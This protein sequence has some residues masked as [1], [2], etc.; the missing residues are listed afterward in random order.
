MLQLN[1][2]YTTANIMIDD[3]EPECMSQITRM[4]NHPVFSKQVVIMP[5]T[6][7]G[8]GSV[9]GFTMP[10]TDL[11]I[12]N[13]IGVDI[14][15]GM[16]SAKL[17]PDLPEKLEKLDRKIQ[18]SI[19]MSTSIHPHSQAETLDFESANKTAQT[20]ILNYNQQFGTNYEMPEYNKDWL[21]KKLLQIGIDPKRFYHSI[22]TLGGGNHFIEIGISDGNYY[23]TVHSGSRHFGAR[24]AEYWQHKAKSKQEPANEQMAD[25]IARLQKKGI[26]GKQLNKKIREINRKNP[27]IKDKDLAPLDG[28]DMMAYLSDMVF[29][30]QYASLNRHSMLRIILENIKVAFSGEIIESVHN[31]IDFE[32]LVIR[33]GAIRSYKTEKMI[34]PFNMRDGILICEGKSNE[35][36]NFSAPHG[37]GRIM[38]RSKA[39]K[40]VDIEDYKKSMQGI[41]STCINKNT[42]DESPMVY[43]NA[44]LI[45]RLI[46][47]TAEVLYKIK[48]V[49]N[50]KAGD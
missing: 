41:Y 7:A 12:P 14:G 50:I 38:S 33:K 18:S 21:K 47:P 31:F 42:L 32:D 26:K 11:L 49:L 45:E 37:A 15:C 29:A 48:P 13:I 34:I 16:I 9:I 4:I 35:E 8:K 17:G 39:K 5:D 43:K 1:G 40:T 19:P 27:V 28:H 2:K 20:F 23:I 10:I 44:K 24:I 25:Q 30:Q 46:Q 3:V 22:G 36:W 6:H